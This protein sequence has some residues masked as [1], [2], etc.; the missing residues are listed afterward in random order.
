MLAYP[1]G[2]GLAV[3]ARIVEQ[4]GGQLRVDSKP[5]VGSRFSFLIPFTL[6]ESA[7]SSP[8]HLL[9]SDENLVETILVNI[10]KEPRTDHSPPKGDS[11][12]GIRGTPEGAIDI[13]DSNHPIRCV[14]ADHYGLDGSPG[15][16][17]AETWRDSLVET[18]KPV[19]PPLGLV[20]DKPSSLRIL[21][22]EVCCPHSCVGY[23]HQFSAKQ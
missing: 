11:R 4:L 19:V 12:S 13:T 8:R 18:D 17:R 5:G 6:P 22:V 2:L 16:S 14:E 15:A 20:I 23:M 9:P 7:K 1:T 10:H 21:V 3:V